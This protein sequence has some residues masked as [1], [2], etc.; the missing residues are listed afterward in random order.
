MKFKLANRF[1]LMNAIAVIS[2]SHL[3]SQEKTVSFLPL[4]AHKN[5]PE[6]AIYQNTNLAPQLRAQDAVKQMT[7]E[8]LLSLTGGWN[9]FYFNGVERLGLRP[10]Y[11]ADASQGVRLRDEE[12]GKYNTTA[13]PGTLALAATWNND[14]AKKMGAALGAEC[15]MRGVDILLGPGINMQRLSVGGRNYEYMGEDPLLTSIMAFSYIKGL[16]SNKVLCTAKHFI[17]NDQEFCRHI[18]SS[19]VDERTL[20]EIY[21][22]PWEAAIKEANV[23]AI[24][25]GNN[26]LNNIPLSMDKQMLV[27]VLRDEYGFNGLFMTDWS[28]TF[29]HP[30]IQYLFLE[31]GMNVLMASNAAF[32]NFLKGYLIKYPDK[33]AAIRA[34]LEKKVSQSLQPLFELGVYDRPLNTKTNQSELETHKTI[35]REIAQEAICLLKNDDNFLPLQKNK[36]VVLMGPTEIQSGVGSGN[37]QGYDHITFADGLKSVFKSKFEEL[38]DFDEEKIRNADV[39]IYR[40]NKEAGEGGDVPFDTGLDKNL[41]KVTALNP[42]VVVVI[43]ACNGL[44]MPW[45][46]KCESGIVELLFRPGKRQRIGRYY[47]GQSKS[48]W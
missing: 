17:C 23:K 41:E 6:G 43:S 45:L 44:S 38:K 15:R 35:A 4:S 24:M 30:E 14:L 22:P 2:C 31:S 40:I 39:V 37:V 13:F 48:I 27:D 47:F 29:Y 20:R 16:Q 8:E 36:S 12:I 19:N 3:Y 18:A 9:K 34:I 21:L 25:T 1:L 33:K 26:L 46:K 11:M 5:F 7:F 42:N 32:S 28:N 10:V